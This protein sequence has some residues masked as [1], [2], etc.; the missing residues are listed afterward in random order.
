MFSLKPTVLLGAVV[1]VAISAVVVLR[2]DIS[3]SISIEDTD[4]ME[5]QLLAANLSE[6]GTFPIIGFLAAPQFYRLDTAESLSLS[7]RIRLE[8][9]LTS[10]PVIGLGKP[11]LYPLILASI[12]SA[13]GLD[14]RIPFWLNIIM[15]AIAAFIIF[16]GVA[17]AMRSFNVLL[18]IP[19]AMVAA[20]YYVYSVHGLI[21][22]ALPGLLM[23][24]LVALLSL[25]ALH[26]RSH[27]WFTGM[28]LGL[29]LLT[30]GNMLPMAVAYIVLL[31]AFWWKGSGRSPLVMALVAALVVLT[32]SAYANV[33]LFRS[34]D[35]RQ[36]W[37]EAMLEDT[38][39]LVQTQPGFDRRANSEQDSL[40]TRL[41]IN[42]MYSR[43]A[44]D[45]FV[46]MSKQPFGDEILSVHNEYAFD[47]SWHPEWRYAANSYHNRENHGAGLLLRVLLFYWDN[48]EFLARNAKGKLLGVMHPHIHALFLSIILL[49][50]MVFLPLTSFWT[51]PLLMVLC[52]SAYMVL[53]P[54]SQ[55]LIFTG[56]TLFSALWIGLGRDRG[57]PGIPVM[58][59]AGALGVV[60]ITFIFIGVP[61]YSQTI[62]PLVLIALAQMA[63]QMKT[64]ARK[65]LG[66]GIE[67]R[68]GQE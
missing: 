26:D 58:L 7:N 63:G 29:L 64:E 39:P 46:I 42:R 28:L 18:R 36:E 1:A 53:D 11:P 6:F 60:S 62:D 12:Y 65:A 23:H 38:L 25:A 8:L 2:A 17:F 3:D 9:T 32:W 37:R 50:C 21:G 33:Q 44:D 61:R 68:E 40:I 41:I 48:P 19:A 51:R 59:T 5:Y 67:L 56:F 57:I 15:M 16:M 66:A 47:G 4:A 55:G 20:T 31:A 27:S 52:C 35:V 30:N 10:G 49:V 24:L 45:G 14:G 34:A 43:Y 54:L 22:F 13:I